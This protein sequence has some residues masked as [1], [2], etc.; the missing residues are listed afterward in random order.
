[1]SARI[2]SYLYPEAN[3][4]NIGFERT[5][6]PDEYFDIMIGNIP[7]GDYRVNDSNYNSHGFLIHDYFIAKTLDK[8]RVGGVAACITTKG[9]MDKESAKVREYLF[10]RA[11]LLG[12][13]RLPNVAFKNAGTK[14]TADILFL[15]K[16]EKIME[17]PKWI[18]IVEDTNGIRMNSYFAEHPEMILGSMKKV[19]GP[20]G[21]ETTCV[22]KEGGSFQEQL[23]SAILHIKGKI[24]PREER[25]EIQY[26]AEQIT[27]I[28]EAS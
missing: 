16:R 3:I 10:S 26:M 12:A 28:P 8:L 7:F 18:S 14:V 22:E 21:M 1:M 2:A 15:Q 27:D 24:P 6:Y 19:S 20:Y 17:H 5:D 25:A 23:H 4:Q 11:E 9:T 13:I